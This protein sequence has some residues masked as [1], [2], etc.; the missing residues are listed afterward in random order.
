MIFNSAFFMFVFLPLCLAGYFLINNKFHN[1]FLMLVSLFFYSWGEPINIVFLLL[2]ISANY[3]LAKAIGRLNRKFKRIVFLFTILANISLLFAFKYFSFVVSNTPFSIGPKHIILPLGISF[4]SFKCLSYV[5]DVYENRIEAEKNIL[6][7]G[8]YVSFFP[9][10]IAGP[11]TRYGDIEPQISDRRVSFEGIYNGAIRF[12]KGFSKKVLISDQ[13]IN[14]VSIIFDSNGYSA[15]IAWLG[16]IAYT[17]EIYF[18]FSGYSDM[19][20]GLGMMFGFE[21]KENFNLPYIATSIQDFWRRWHIS[22]STWFRDY[23]YY[24]LGGSYCSKLRTYFN[25]L[26]VFGLTGLWHG[27]NWNFVVWGLFYALFLIA[28]RAGLKNI[29]V[30]LPRLIQHIYALSVIIIGWVFFRANNINAALRYIKNMFSINSRWYADLL[31]IVDKQL[32]FCIILGIVFSFGFSV[33][34]EKRLVDNRWICDLMIVMIFLI[35]IGYMWGGGFSPFL[36]SQF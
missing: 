14:I 28:E 9:Q 1:I 11:I 5:I 10:L 27:A 17:I 3:A 20:I 29:L 22:L 24:P 21:T 13:L 26:V 19:A 16:A 30:K 25:V 12:M 8:L 33:W 4:Y 35:A 34:L 2:S 18:D 7:F 23:V 6:K 32:V 31:S 15:P 36:Y